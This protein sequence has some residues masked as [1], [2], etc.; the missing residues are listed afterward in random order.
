MNDYHQYN[1]CFWLRIASGEEKWAWA[2]KEE[3]IDEM[4]YLSSIQ[5]DI[6]ND[7]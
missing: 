2:K 5:Y 1:D 7:T 6:E 3:D 4:K